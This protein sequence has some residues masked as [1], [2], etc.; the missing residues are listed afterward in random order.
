MF[1]QALKTHKLTIFNA[2]TCL[3]HDFLKIL[4]FLLFVVVANQR[5]GLVLAKRNVKS[6]NWEN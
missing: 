3:L 5:T 4:N 6:G 1:P 2:H